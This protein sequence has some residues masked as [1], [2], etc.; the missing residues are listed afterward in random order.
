MKAMNQEVRDVIRKV[1]LN[2]AEDLALSRKCNSLGMQRSPA[3]RALINCWTGLKHKPRK[4]RR[5]GPRHGHVL[6]CTNRAT[7]GGARLPLR[8]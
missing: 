6:N 3:I 7:H 2:A 1:V 5:A 4:L 8:V